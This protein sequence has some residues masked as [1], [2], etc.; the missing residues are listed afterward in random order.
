VGFK[1]VAD[2]AA[3][4]D[5]SSMGGACGLLIIDGVYS[6]VPLH[7]TLTVQ[8]SVLKTFSKVKSNFLADP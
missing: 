8:G 6:R 5:D 4:A 1:D 7:K 2:G 3:K